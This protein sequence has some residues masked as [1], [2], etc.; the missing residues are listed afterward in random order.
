MPLSMDNLIAL[1][2]KYEKDHSTGASDMAE[3]LLNRYGL[4]ININTFVQVRSQ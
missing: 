2:E 3:A 1:V 4:R